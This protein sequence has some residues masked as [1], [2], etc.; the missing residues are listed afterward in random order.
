MAVMSA[1]LI[2]NSVAMGAEPAPGRPASDP[3][4]F[5]RDI[6]PLLAKHCLECHGTDKSESGL[7]LDTG[8]SIR[9]GGDGAG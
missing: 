7:R 1:L 9:A 6:Q 2:S 5:S 3:I 8:R 4:V